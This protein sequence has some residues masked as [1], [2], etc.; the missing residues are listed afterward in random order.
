MVVN[1]RGVIYTH[2][3][4]VDVYGDYEESR[5]PGQSLVDWLM[6][7]DGAAGCPGA[8]DFQAA[9]D[10][11]R[12]EAASEK[13]LIRCHSCSESRACPHCDGKGHNSGAPCRDCHGTGV[14]PYC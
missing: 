9:A 3:T 14:C 2:R 11:L 8:V 4:A 7:N 6:E 12:R 5:R 1:W 10:S 13:G